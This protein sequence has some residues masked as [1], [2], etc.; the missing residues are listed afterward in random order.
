LP[1]LVNETIAKNNF[2]DLI[3][4][5]RTHLKSTLDIAYYKCGRIEKDDQVDF[6]FKHHHDV[7]FLEGSSLDDVKCLGDDPNT[8]K[9]DEF[10]YKMYS[11]AKY[12]KLIFLNSKKFD[13]I[14]IINTQSE[15]LYVVALNVG[16]FHEFAFV[17]LGDVKKFDAGL[18]QDLLDAKEPKSQNEFTGVIILGG[19]LH[20]HLY[21]GDIRRFHGKSSFNHYA[22]QITPRRMKGEPRRFE[23]LMCNTIPQGDLI[24]VVNSCRYEFHDPDDSYVHSRVSIPNLQDPKLLLQNYTESECAPDSPKQLIDKDEDF[25]SMDSTKREVR[26]D[27][28]RDH[29]SENDTFP[30]SDEMN[31][32]IAQRLVWLTETCKAI[33]VSN[34]LRE[35]FYGPRGGIFYISRMGTKTYT[36]GPILLVERYRLKECVRD[37]FSYLNGIA[38]LKESSSQKDTTTG[39][40]ENP[41]LFDCVKVVGKYYLVHV[42]P[43]GG[44]FIWRCNVKKYYHMRSDMQ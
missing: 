9:F 24:H 17:H 44:R 33:N 27:S 15:I 3:N 42:G 21:K 5:T 1:S 29:N 14:S 36:K 28:S 22:S 34:E 11:D 16:S 23:V 30:I 18:C 7:I 8:K 2:V 43:R 6:I 40:S 12:T 31:S 39:G 20:N 38:R 41:T 13:N 4:F 35:V 10:E 19:W 32:S 37:M 25:G 26:E